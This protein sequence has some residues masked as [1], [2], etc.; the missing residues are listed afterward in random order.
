MQK[1]ETIKTNLI[2]CHG[3]PEETA[4]IL[5]EQFRTLRAKSYASA[6]MRDN[7]DTPMRNDPDQA[8]HFQESLYD[9]E[10]ENV[11]NEF[12]AFHSANTITIHTLPKM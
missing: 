1:Q 8:V 2:A 11:L 6:P 4:D 7:K 9:V 10:E 12:M 5:A 3:C